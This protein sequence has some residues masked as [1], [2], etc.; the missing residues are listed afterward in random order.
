MSMEL[1]KSGV[2]IL[3]EILYADAK[4]MAQMCQLSLQGLNSGSGT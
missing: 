3:A 2:E 4:D 1:S